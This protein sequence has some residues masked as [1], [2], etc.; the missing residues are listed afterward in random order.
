MQASEK[1][2]ETR[3][4][5]CCHT[6]NSSRQTSYVKFM[7]CKHHNCNKSIETHLLSKTISIHEIMNT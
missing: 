4:K 7:K 3:S 6:I 2:K 1:S 5:P